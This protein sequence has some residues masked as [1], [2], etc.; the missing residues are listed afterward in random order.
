[1][2]PVTDYSPDT[3]ACIQKGFVSWIWHILAES[4]LRDYAKSKVFQAHSFK[5][6]TP[7]GTQLKELEEF[8]TSQGKTLFSFRL[9]FSK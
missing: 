8:V 6:L 5:E 2:F 3:Y 4:V 1:V 9:F 7:L